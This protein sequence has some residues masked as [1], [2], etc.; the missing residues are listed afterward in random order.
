MKYLK[1][2]G[3][4]AIAAAALM[5]FAGSASA[6]ELTSPAGT[7]VTTGT[8]I[9]SSSEGEAVL[10]SLVGEIKCASTVEGT[11]S[12]TGGTGESVEGSI[13][14]LDFTGCTD[15]ADVTVV[16]GRTGTLKITSA[17]GGTGTLES[18]GAEVTVEV[19][20]AHCIFKTS[21]TVLG[22]VTSSTEPKA[23]EFTDATLDISARIPRSG[24]RSG[25]LCGSTAPWTGSY[26]VTSPTPLFID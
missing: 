22:T 18:T 20:G 13:S 19:F 1:I 17:G 12:N 5:A 15:G 26:K 4:A 8:T 23:G 16:S 6:T 21:S 2:L 14:T 10:D 11:T 3:L 9:S 24:G 25:A 7:M